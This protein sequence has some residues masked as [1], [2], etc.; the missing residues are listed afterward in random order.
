LGNARRLVEGY[1]GNIISGGI[2]YPRGSK[3]IT[4]AMEK[5]YSVETIP[6]D[7]GEKVSSYRKH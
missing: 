5:T 1:R 6:G 3:L 7:I 4:K 2:K